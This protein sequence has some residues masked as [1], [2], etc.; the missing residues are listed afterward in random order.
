MNEPEKL[1][2]AYLQATNEI[3]RCCTHAILVGNTVILQREKEKKIPKTGKKRDEKMFIDGRIKLH[4][5]SSVTN[6][7]QDFGLIICYIL[8]WYTMQGGQQPHLYLSSVRYGYHWVCRRKKG[9]KK[10]TKINKNKKSKGEI[11]RK[12]EGCN[13]HCVT[14]YINLG[15][16]CYSQTSSPFWL[17][18]FI[19]FLT[20]NGDRYQGARKNVA[21]RGNIS[22]SANSVALHTTQQTKWPR[23]I[24]LFPYDKKG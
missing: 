24:V 9:A 21:D 14:L 4:N 11:I 16:G 7:H 18:T 15:I 19:D 10:I 17:R 22:Y 3:V 5:R 12:T 23:T 1:I 20:F 2:L 6:L 8:W 13:E